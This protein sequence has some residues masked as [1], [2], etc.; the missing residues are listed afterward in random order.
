MQGGQLLEKIQAT[1]LSKSAHLFSKPIGWISSIIGIT[2]FLALGIGTAGVIETKIAIWA[3]SLVLA[4]FFSFIINKLVRPPHFS[5]ESIGILLAIKTDSDESQNRLENDLAQALHEGLQ[6]A[7][8][9]LP[10]EVKVLQQLHVPNVSD[11]ESATEYAKITGARFVI[12]G[13]LARRKIKAEDHYILHVSALVTHTPTT[14]ENQSTLSQE[15]T[16]VLPVKANIA[17]SNDFEGLELTGHL[18]GL[19]SQYVIA[20]AMFISG[21]RSSAISVLNDLN[22]KLA[23]ARLPKEW[24]G[25]KTLVNLVPKRLLDFQLGEIDHEYFEWRTDHSKERLQLIDAKFSQLPESWKKDGRYLN[26][27]AICHFVLNNNVDAARQLLHKVGSISPESIVWRYSLAFLDAYEGNISNA[28]AGYLRAFRHDHTSDIAL[29]VEE[30]MSWIVDSEQNQEHLYFFLGFINFHKKKDANSAERDLQK[31][32]A[33]HAS[34][35]H[36]ELT[37]EARQMIH[38]CE[39]LKTAIG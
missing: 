30:F 9:S 14:L 25:S 15:M 17:A 21:D 37:D 26:I 34:K 8:T 39:T 32:L 3:T 22:N 18:F 29:E 7:N 31:Y 35:K 38:E 27:R 13:S 5:K 4:I 16:A 20:A 28:R 23:N 19:G 1:A 12:Y 6:A 2:L 33:S 24:P 11:L 36:S 10:I